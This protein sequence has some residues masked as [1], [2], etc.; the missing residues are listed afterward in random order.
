MYKDVYIMYF[1]YSVL[2]T[3]TRCQNWIPKIPNGR[4]WA[5]IAACLKWPAKTP[6]E[7][8]VGTTAMAADLVG[9]AAPDFEVELEDGSKKKLSAFLAEGHC[10]VWKKKEAETSQ[11]DEGGVVVL[12]IFL[13][14]AGQV[15]F[16]FIF[17]R[18]L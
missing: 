9:K 2:P 17:K 14:E 6:P 16:F 3:L 1:L 10:R 7:S 15:E 13:G 18:A 8:A 5:H 12:E 11:S 4:S